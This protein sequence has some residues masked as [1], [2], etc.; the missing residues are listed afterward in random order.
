M[1]KYKILALMSGGAVAV[2]A[3][4]ADSP[5]EKVPS[6]AYNVI[7]IISDQ[8]KLSVTGCY[9]DPVVKTPNLDRLAAE[10]VM[11][12]HIYTPCPLSAPARAAI[13]TGTYPSVNGAMLHR[14]LIQKGDKTVETE[15]GKFRKGYGEGMTTWGEYMKSKGYSTA[16]IGKMH[17]HGELQDGVNPDFPKGNHLGFDVS[18]MRFYTFYPGGH[19]KDWKGNPDYYARYREIQDYAPY[20][21]GNNFN[22]ELKPTLVEKEEDIFDFAVVSTCEDYMK[23]YLASGSKKPFFLHVGL[24]KPHKPW[25]TSQRFYDLYSLDEMKIPATQRDWHENGRYPFIKKGTHNPLTDTLEIKKSMIAYYGCVSEVDV[26]VGELIEETKR[27][28]IYDKTIFIYTTDHGEHLYEH[29]FHEKHNMF[30]DAVNV[31]FIIS[32]PALLPKGVVCNS[33]GS[34]LD[35][36][37]TISEL[38]GMEPDPQ[39]QGTSLLSQIGTDKPWDRM[40]YSEFYQ[41]DFLPFPNKNVPLKMGRD[42]QFKYVYSHGM[43]DQLY[44][45]T[46]GDQDE[47]TNLALNPKYDEI[48]E[49]YKFRTIAGWKIPFAKNLD[50]RLTGDKKQKTISWKPIP[51]AKSYTVWCSETPDKD[52]AVKI[53][54]TRQ[55]SL[56]VSDAKGKYFWVMAKWKFTKMSERSDKIPMITENFPEYLPISDMLT[57]KK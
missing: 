10:G 44:D 3:V 13:T 35:V 19:Y 55:N 21:K 34:L 2:P 25:T 28:G 1:N 42:P 9:G 33:V 17:V 41:T 4:M 43:I 46:G 57:A 15:A 27:L 6:D 51:E 11:F 53:G 20:F 56:D 32:C 23:D 54:W 48:V 12:T 18:D 14:E 30:E 47:M 49:R 38:L 36:L 50:A 5:K 45:A 16:A 29:G 7:F 37:P 31:P 24:E 8:H 26:N 52:Q 39:W 22:Q 40:V